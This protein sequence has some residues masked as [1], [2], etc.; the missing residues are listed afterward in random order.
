MVEFPR[1]AV[2][3]P[4]LF[5]LAVPRGAYLAVCEWSGSG[6]RTMA[7]IV[8][9]RHGAG[10]P[11]EIACVFAAPLLVPTMPAL[12]NVE[13]PLVYALTGASERRRR[14]MAALDIAGVA[15]LAVRAPE[16]MSPA[17]AKMVAIARALVVAP[18]LI[19]L[20]EPTAD[21]D[22]REAIRVLALLDR[23]NAAGVTQLVITRD[24]RVAARAG[25]RVP[26]LSPAV[27][28]DDGPEP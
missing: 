25:Y 14:A 22:R 6:E 5:P 19:V 8:G 7:R 3:V 10:D 9:A 2:A 18:E 17:E 24:P 15:G 12:A 4:G 28:C 26:G 23:L 21:L 1:R 11:A 27:S 13:L 20:D 16:E